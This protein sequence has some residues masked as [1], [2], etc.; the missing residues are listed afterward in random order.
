MSATG[1]NMPASRTPVDQLSI[2]YNVPL[3]LA[4]RMIGRTEE[5]TDRNIAL[6]KDYIA[7][8]V[9]G[10]FDYI[11]TNGWVLQGDFKPKG[12]NDAGRINIPLHDATLNDM[13]CASLDT[14]YHAHGFG[15][16]SPLD[17]S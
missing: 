9:A 14:D 12:T 11:S 1:N 4:N 7:S 2:D 10:Y 6:F 16:R 13:G 3:A 8:V 15:C 17:V 5:E